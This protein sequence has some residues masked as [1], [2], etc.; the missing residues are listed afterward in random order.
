MAD[1]NAVNDNVK[2]TTAEA[3]STAAPKVGSAS[4]TTTAVETK[5]E[6]KTTAEA[7]KASP[8]VDSK[9]T[10]AETKHFKPRR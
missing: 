2:A 7:A 4:A 6:V 5:S 9:D 8:V 1:T 3:V 10:K